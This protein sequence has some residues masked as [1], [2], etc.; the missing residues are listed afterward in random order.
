MWIALGR[1]A[2]S[3]RV[4]VF[5]YYFIAI[6]AGHFDVTINWLQYTYYLKHGQIVFPYT[7]VYKNISYLIQKELSPIVWNEISYLT[8]FK[9]NNNLMKKMFLIVYEIC[10]KILNKIILWR[11]MK[12]NVQF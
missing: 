9:A 7:K 4:L 3:K 2:C 1:W 8:F 10:M 6:Q 12:E 11:V 5:I